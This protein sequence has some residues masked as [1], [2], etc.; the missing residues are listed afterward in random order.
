MNSS[1]HLVVRDHADNETQSTLLFDCPVRVSHEGFSRV[2]AGLIFEYE[3]TLDGVRIGTHTDCEGECH[4][5]ASEIERLAEHM[6]VC[7]NEACGGSHT[8]EL[9]HLARH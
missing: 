7:D 3:D 4:E 8:A 2:F 6:H 5:F 9:L 1:C